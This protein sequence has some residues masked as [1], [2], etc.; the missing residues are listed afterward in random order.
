VRRRRNGGA[1]RQDCHLCMH[2]HRAAPAAPP[3]PSRLPFPPPRPIAAQDPCRF[4]A[5]KGVEDLLAAGGPRVLPVIPQL[6]I[7]LKTALNTRD[8]AVMC[9]TLQV[10]D[11]RA[12][13][14]PPRVGISHRRQRQSM[15][16]SGLLRGP[17]AGLN[18]AALTSSP[19]RRPPRRPPRRAPCRRAP[20]LLQKLVLSGDLVGEALV[21]YYRQLLPVLNIYINRWGA[22]RWEGGQAGAW[23]WGEGWGRQLAG[24]RRAHE[25]RSSGAPPSTAHAPPPP[26]LPPS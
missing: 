2:R 9:V 3:T 14:R 4:L 17:R 13:P 16:R 10:R 7:P 5:I 6:I 20:Q 19:R 1:A 21:P 22:G 24:H 11:A 26:P 25:R 23:A 12:P 18:C 8:P 15:H